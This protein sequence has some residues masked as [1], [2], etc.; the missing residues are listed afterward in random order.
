[1][2]DERMFVG[3]V[4]VAAEHGTEQQQSLLSVSLDRGLSQ[5]NPDW[6]GQ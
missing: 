1:M 4:P 2:A 5:L 3:S 6:F